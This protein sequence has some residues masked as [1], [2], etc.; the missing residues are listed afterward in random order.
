MHS[1]RKTVWLALGVAVAGGLGSLAILRSVLPGD[2]QAERRGVT[3]AA[4]TAV[5]AGLLLISATRRFW[6]RAHHRHRR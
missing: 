3:L 4:V 5:L 6:F 2:V 1:V